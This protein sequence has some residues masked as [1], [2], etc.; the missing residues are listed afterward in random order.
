MVFCQIKTILL[1]TPHMC[2][3]THTNRQM[4]MHTPLHAHMHECIHIYIGIHAHTEVNTNIKKTK[5]IM[6]PCQHSLLLPLFC[7]IVTTKYTILNG[8]SKWHIKGYSESCI[9]N[10]MSQAHDQQS[11][12]CEFSA[13]VRF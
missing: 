4:H 7:S 10:Y 2:G 13:L 6:I 1:F 3:C 12:S 5:L 11:T 8:Y 9:Q